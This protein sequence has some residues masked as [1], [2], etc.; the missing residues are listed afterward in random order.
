MHLNYIQSAP[1][2]LL[3]FLAN[4]WANVHIFSPLQFIAGTFS[5]YLLGLLGD[6]LVGL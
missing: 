3:V 1:F 2:D 4:Q 5:N 6:Y